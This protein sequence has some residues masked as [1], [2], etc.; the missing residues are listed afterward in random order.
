MTL[1]SRVGVV[2]ITVSWA[3]V[4]VPAAS[5]QS[6]PTTATGYRPDPQRQDAHRRGALRAGLSARPPAAQ[7]PHH[8]NALRDRIPSGP[9]RSHG[10]EVH[11]GNEAMT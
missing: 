7:D 1:R 10:D 4:T 2:A 11:E 8:G 9:L 6:P 5:A 3:L